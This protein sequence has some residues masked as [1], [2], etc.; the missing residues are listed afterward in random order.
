MRARPVSTQPAD[1]VLLMLTP[2]LEAE[3]RNRA[4][5]PG[6]RA[7]KAA[8]RS[9]A[10]SIFYVPAVFAREVLEDA[11]NRMQELGSGRGVYQAYRALAEHMKRG[12][13][14]A[15]GVQPDPG[16]DKWAEEYGSVGCLQA[17]Y[18]LQDDDGETVIL[19]EGYKVRRCNQQ[20][21][22][23]R[24]DSGRRFAYRP[25]YVGVVMRDGEAKKFFYAACDLF[26]PSG[27]VTHLRLVCV[28]GR[29]VR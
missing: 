5:F 24:D 26:S 29:R 17:G 14:R 18:K 13:D 10:T 21:G 25:G 27:D 22:P 15:E 7:D 28:D 1:T 2:T 8:K 12:I 3:Y 20:N 19:S 11:K 16:L 9:G 23:F 6:L 4:A